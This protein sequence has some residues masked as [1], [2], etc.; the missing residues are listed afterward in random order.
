MKEPVP[1]SFSLCIGIAAALGRAFWSTYS[2]GGSYGRKLQY[3]NQERR[4]GPVVLEVETVESY[5]ND[6]PPEIK[7]YWDYS[8]QVLNADSPHYPGREKES[9][10][11]V[12]DR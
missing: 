5:P 4:L 10:G 2:A 9:M 1:A 12:H 11:H 8:S 6:T 3:H 7:I